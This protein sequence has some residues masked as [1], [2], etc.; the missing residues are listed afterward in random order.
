[1]RHSSTRARCVEARNMRTA[2]VVDEL[3]LCTLR[4]ACARANL[5]ARAQLRAASRM[6]HRAIE[7]FMH[8]Q[9]MLHLHNHEHEEPRRCLAPTH[10]TYTAHHT[11]RAP[12]PAALCRRASLL[13]MQFDARLHRA[14]DE[15]NHNTISCRRIS[16]SPIQ[17]TMTAT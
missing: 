11:S 5:Q 8:T 16:Y 15:Q 3:R 14:I 10:C 7:P 9:T 1:M 4:S 13:P 2:H 6:D 17:T 12:Q